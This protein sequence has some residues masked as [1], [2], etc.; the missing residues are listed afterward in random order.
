MANA[1]DDKL[2][3]NPY[4]VLCFANLRQQRSEVSIRGDKQV[5]WS[6]NRGAR[7]SGNVPQIWFPKTS[8]M[9]REIA[10]FSHWSDRKIN[11]PAASTVT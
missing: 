2:L 7:A 6:L 4:Y 11:M 1:R 10:L 8:H 9:S 5:I 3:P